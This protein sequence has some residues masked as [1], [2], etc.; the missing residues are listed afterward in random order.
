MDSIAGAINTVAFHH[1]V[2]GTWYVLCSMRQLLHNIAPSV[3]ISFLSFQIYQSFRK[4]QV[5]VS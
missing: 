5:I 2:Y 1:F 3:T 4:L